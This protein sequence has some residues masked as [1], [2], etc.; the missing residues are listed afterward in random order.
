MYN[1]KQLISEIATKGKKSESRSGTTTSVFGRQLRFDLNE[2]FPLLD[3]KFTSFNN[4]KQELLWFLSGSTNIND[5]GNK[6]WNEWATLDGS[7]GKIYG[8][9]WR[10][11]GGRGRDQIQELVDG[12]K[13]RP[14]SR[15]HIVSAWN[16]EDLP[17][18]SVSP[19][20]NVV[21]GKMALAPCHV[22]FQCYV[23]DGL[24]SLQVY[25]RSAM[26]ALFS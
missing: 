17:D 7:L 20:A 6:I 12:I 13:A 26:S 3:L 8:S 2:G 1:Y 15:R 24:L 18:E 10:T 4:I 16:V 5:L 22:M 19:Q 23:E 9:Q 14:H 11:W 25:Q 21:R